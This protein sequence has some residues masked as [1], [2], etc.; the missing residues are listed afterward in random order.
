VDPGQSPHLGRPQLLTLRTLG[1][2]SLERDGQPVPE[3]EAQRNGL[4]VLAIL[5]VDGAA[6]RDRLMALLWPESDTPRARGSLKQTLYQL[7]RFL[8]VPDVLVGSTTLSLDSARITTDAGQFLATLVRDDAAAVAYYAGPLLDGVHLG[9]SAELYRWVEERRADLAARWA[10]AV[11]RLA[12]AAEAA[13]D[14]RAAARYW[15]L[16]QGHD[17]ADSRVTIR[18]M[19]A[20]EAAGRRA[21]ALQEAREHQRRLADDWELGPDPAV[22][23]LATRLQA[24]R[25]GP[26]EAP[27][28]PFRGVQQR[29][30]TRNDAPD[31][32][33]RA[34]ALDAEHAQA[35]ATPTRATRTTRATR[36]MLAEVAALLV[37]TAT[38]AWL[39]SRRTAEPPSPPVEPDLVAVA[40]FQSL[41]PSLALWGEG[42]ADVLIRDLDGAGPLRTVAGAVSFRD[43]PGNAD[44]AA[45]T[46]LGRRTGAELVIYGT[47]MRLDADTVALRAWVLDRSADQSAAEL[48]VRGPEAGLGRLADSLSFRILEALG[49]DRPIASARRVSLAARSLP[50][51]RAFLR[52]EQFYRHGYWDSAMVYYG[53]AVEA[54]PE[55]ALAFKRM[56]MLDGWGATAPG[57]L[58]G[59]E[60]LPRAV[61]LNRGLA[62]RDSLLLVSDSVGLAALGTADPEAAVRYLLR[63]MGALEEA[64]RRYPDDPDVHYHLGEARIHSPHPLGGT[65]ERA[66]EPFER[67]IALDPGFLPAYEHAVELAFQVGRPERG[68]QYARAAAAL[69]S[70]YDASTWHLLALVLDSGV[71]AAPT[72][73][74]LAAA[75][76]DPLFRLGSYLRWSTD[77][78]EAAVAAFR[79]LLDPRHAG[80]TGGLLVSDLIL[81]GRHL[82]QALAFRGHLRAAAEQGWQQPTGRALVMA[83]WVDPFLELALFGAVPDS[84]A[85]RVFGQ[86]LAPDAEWGGRVRPFTP[87]YL[88][89]APWWFAR[90]D[91]L[92]LHRFAARGAEEARNAGSPVAA[93]RG[94]YFASAAAGYLALSRG[95]SLQ[96]ARIFAAIPDTLCIVAPCRYEKLTLAQLLAAAGEH[97]PAANLLDQWGT[98]GVGNYVISG[99][100]PTAVLA[101]LE[102]ARVAERLGDTATARRKYR[103]VTEAWRGADRELQPWVAEARARLTRLED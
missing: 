98:A 96:A 21:A 68:R 20:L 49:R 71:S 11:E 47:V 9:G 64:A 95:D 8:G 58:P 44:R 29:A 76:A 69:A 19:L 5:A 26:A 74:A 28:S 4:A 3:F 33:T 27:E 103:F 10:A 13:G 59:D 6:S 94:R 90:G 24:G 37:L 16:L 43:W 102:R 38:A 82:A 78:T 25:V 45:A 86:A 85:A 40:P 101:A 32:P 72:G 2:L 18:L 52:G 75:P 55:F 7:R 17:P 53:R 92:A 79:E 66:L 67:T 14:P 81:R 15:R 56:S 31:A 99:D 51:L 88:R 39:A 70:G 84:V 65:P 91:T 100:T 83:P 30:T 36:R 77:S 46:D 22:A 80:A 93:Y 60:Y 34:D 62:P 87:R 41:D 63:G 42:L 35:G 97:E 89:G 73:R 48:E 57:D 12:A 61:V 23:E 50:A 1:R 54:D